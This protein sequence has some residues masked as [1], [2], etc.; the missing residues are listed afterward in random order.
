[1]PL[2]PVER[3]NR[4]A[5]MSYLHV[6]SSTNIKRS[7]FLRTRRN[8]RAAVFADW[9]R[10]RLRKQKGEEKMP[11]AFFSS[12][13]ATGF[14]SLPP[15]VALVS[16]EN[17]FQ[18]RIFAGRKPATKRSQKIKKISSDSTHVQQKL[19]SPHPRSFSPPVLLSLGLE[20]TWPN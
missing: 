2:Q 5:T 3:K 13:A 9:R 11:V 6:E 1:M 19:F 16:R 14:L 20:V 15:L 12:F 10:R 4:R 7:S 17:S 18:K 8:E